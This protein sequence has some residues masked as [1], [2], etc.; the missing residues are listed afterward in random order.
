MR[1]LLAHN[2]LYYPSH[3]GGDIS[4]R[5]LMEALAARGHVCR[6]VARLASFGPAEHERFLESLRQRSVTVESAASGVVTFNHAGV[7]VHVLTAQAS[8]R[9]YFAQQVGEFSPSVILT[10]T[11]DPAQL[12]LEAAL[13]AEGPRVV[14]LVRATLAVP[15]GPD[16]AFPSES[17]TD[18]LRRADG[19]VGVSQYVADYVRRWSG[20]PAIHVPISLMDKGPFPELGNI[21]NELVTLV[22][23]CAVKGI[24]IFLA[25]A[26]RM[27]EVRFAAVPTW[28]T[29]EADRAALAARPNVCVLDP[30]DDIDKL[31]MRTSVLL[32]PSLWAEARS[33]IVVEAMLRGVPVIASDVGGIPEAKMGVDYLLPVH[34]IE[35]YEPRLDA[36]MVPVADVPEQDIG[37]WQDALHRLVSEPRHYRELSRASREAA[38]SYVEN[39]SIRPFENFLEEIERSPVRSRSA[40]AASRGATP[41]SVLEGLSPEKRRLLAL[42]LRKMPAQGVVA[43]DPWF[44]ST[45]WNDNARLR[46]FCFP[47]AGAGVSSFRNWTREVSPEI[48]LVPV[49]LPGRENRLKEPPIRRMEALVGALIA[50]IRPFLDRPFAFYGHSLGAVLA[51]ELSRRLR[52]EGLPAPQFLCVAGARAPQYRLGHKPPAEPSDDRLIDELRRLEGVPAEILDNPELL[53][54]VLPAL[55]ADTELY[56]NYV[57]SPGAPLGCPIR[58]FGGVADPNVT[59]EHLE[60]WAHQ[61]TSSFR[62]RMFEGGHFFVDTARVEFLRALS[63]ELAGE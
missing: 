12:L 38:L 63:L 50:P 26:D 31:L 30:V 1:I 54:V 6:V 35:R 20:I 61:T 25:L 37:P 48:S 56:R 44:P 5:L 62:L 29:N 11:D 16:A 36:Q 13:R 2:S 17:K 47:S 41:S 28:G 60:A 51:F 49:R 22:N 34:P 23:P 53:Q 39:L 8:P 55:R 3:G 33:R 24:S 18:M 21:D 32:V 19:V 45:E 4:N 58:A 14:Y 52:S 7:E 40:V 59:R 42:R 9:G 46:L 15:F 57:Y 27:P 43:A 10:S